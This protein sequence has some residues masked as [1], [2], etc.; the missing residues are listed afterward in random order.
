L[1]YDL[2]KR[3]KRI[4]DIQDPDPNNPM[5]L[6]FQELQ[7]TVRSYTRDR[8]WFAKRRDS[9]AAKPHETT[10]YRSSRYPGPDQRR[11]RRAH[12]KRTSQERGGSRWPFL[13]TS[14]VT[15][16]VRHRFAVRA[17]RCSLAG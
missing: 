16:P 6:R 4:D 17:K 7:R 3:F 11:G 10:A 15:L 8:S 9:R 13:A 14:K 2:Q 12:G 5:R 1:R